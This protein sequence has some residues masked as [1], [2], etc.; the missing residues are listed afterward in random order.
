MLATMGTA[1][2]LEKFAPIESFYRLRRELTA[3]TMV[4]ITVLSFAVG[5]TLGDPR[6]AIA[7]M[8]LTSG[9]F[10]WR[11]LYDLSA[12]PVRKAIPMVNGILTDS[13]VGPG[14]FFC[15]WK[16]LLLL[17]YDEQ[18][19]GDF[20]T[21]FDVIE[22]VPGDQSMIDVPNNIY[23]LI[24]PE[25]PHPIIA[26]G[27]VDM[28]LKRLQEQ[29]TQ[30][31]RDWLCSEAEGPQDLNDARRMGDEAILMILGKLLGDEV[32]RLHP[33]ITNEAI[34]GFLKGRPLT[35]VEKALKV[36]FDKL[37]PEEQKKLLE[38]A[39]ENLIKL[40]DQTRSG[41]R[42]FRLPNLGLILARF[43]IGNIEATE[44]TKESVARLNAAKFDA[45][46]EATNAA[47]V[48]TQ[49]KLNVEAGIVNTKDALQQELIRRKI[50][51]EDIK[52]TRLETSPEIL[53]TI[54]ALPGLIIGG[55]MG[56]K[57]NPRGKSPDTNNPT[58]PAV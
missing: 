4:A 13:L 10:F 36:E 33:T 8:V 53:Q 9:I 21:D 42:I 37:L 29:L 11:S 20:T 27:G 16:G 43:G 50:V 47:S 40:I 46:V 55:I 17:D 3:A 24:D 32:K 56:R 34:V 12:D 57:E 18:P 38:D 28:A 48:R 25:N 30:Y 39:E 19:G 52:V 26:I 58:P 49:A 41:Q 23:T 54:E 45:L 44:E 7:L 2:E 14:W 5:I 35:K 15:P 51:P 6:P 22:M 31:Q 1:D